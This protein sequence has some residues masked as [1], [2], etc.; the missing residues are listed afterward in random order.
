MLFFLSGAAALVFEV[1]AMKALTSSL[2]SSTYASTTTIAA[3]MAGLALGARALGRRADGHPRP[4]RLYGLV[5]LGV[6]AAG[7]LVLGAVALLAHGALPVPAALRASPGGFLLARGVVLLLALLPATFLMGGSL[8]VM[9]RAVA[10]GGAA[11]AAF[12][13]PL[14]AANTLG[15]ASG[16]LA[17]GFVLLPHLGVR[18]T[19]LVALAT[20]AAVGLVALSLDPARRPAPAPLHPSPAAPARLSLAA[21]A[22]LLGA[23]GFVLLALEHVWF[24]YLAILLGSSTYSFSVLLAGVIAGL[25]LGSL[26][27]G[28]VARRGGLGPR[29]LALALVLEAFALLAPLPLYDD[30]GYLVWWAWSQLGGGWEAMTVLKAATGVLVTGVPSAISGFVFAG[31]LGM[32]LDDPDEVG[33]PAGVVAAVNTLGGLAGIVASAFWMVPTLG[34]RESVEAL[35]LVTLALAAALSLGFPPRGRARTAPL[36]VL[37]A[38]LAYWQ[39]RTPWV[40]P[41]IGGGAFR[42]FRAGEGIDLDAYWQQL[43]DQDRTVQFLE[44]GVE[45]T[46]SVDRG[47]PTELILRVNGK[48]DASSLGDRVTQSMLA[49]L[50]LLLHPDPREVLV[51][52]LGSG[53]TAGAVTLHPETRVDVCEIEPA[54]IR[55][56]RFFRHWNH[57]VLRSPRVTVHA[58]DARI[59]LERTDRRYDVIISEPS[60]PWMAGVAQLF[61]VET[62]QAVRRHLRPGGVY[63]Q[64][65]HLY[66]T[67]RRTLSSLA[68]SFQEVFPGASLWILAKQDVA[69]VTGRDGPVAPDL[70]RVARRMAAD[71]LREDLLETSVRDPATLLAGNLLGPRSLAAWVQEVPAP[72]NTDDLPFVEYSAPRAF[73]DST[74]VPPPQLAGDS[75]FR[76]LPEAFRDAGTDARVAAL[77]ESVGL[78][79]AATA[80]AP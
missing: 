29:G 45:S 51:I 79:A 47:R 48:P 70:A 35:A 16:A 39:V 57:R 42:D 9:V 27:A 77:H 4:M 28:R 25:G 3:Y 34:L 76:A 66:E 30:L 61:T 10:A 71:P 53:M 17:A 26:V 55:A 58:E 6:A 65:F 74:A 33:R 37:L 80:P 59:F 19:L 54:V 62:F 22:G 8:P 20:Y 2:G 52:G 69:L 32:V 13:P 44:H 15:A 36:V 43:T 67:D 14:Y 41:R 23:T 68:G 7:L 24:R 31:A 5:E 46:V 75:L 56:A 63:L 1:A 73:V 64:W 38:C 78:T 50:P 21:A 11:P 60:N 49:H 40:W 18:G 12:V 72:K